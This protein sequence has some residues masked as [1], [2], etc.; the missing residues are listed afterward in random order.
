MD[1]TVFKVISQEIST[2]S[3]LSAD[4]PMVDYASHPAF[5]FNELTL[6]AS[7]KIKIIVDSIGKNL[8]RI[9]NYPVNKN[10]LSN[11]E[12]DNILNKNDLEIDQIIERVEE[13]RANQI[14]GEILSSLV[15]ALTLTKEKLRAEVIFK[16]GQLSQYKAD[17]DI[18]TSVEQL[19][20]YGFCTFSIKRDEIANINKVLGDDISKLKNAAIKNSKSRINI[21]YS[22]GKIYKKLKSIIKYSTPD[23]A[24]G[25]HYGCEMEVDAI[26]LEYSHSK[27]TWYKNCY[28]DKKIPTASTVYFH[29][30]REFDRHKMIINL[31]VVGKKNGPFSYIPASNKMPRNSFL[32]AFHKELDLVLDRYFQDNFII[33][34][35]GYYRKAFGDPYLRSELEKIPP[36]LLGHSHFGD[37]LLDGDQA[38]LLLQNEFFLT[39][40]IANVALF[41]GHNGIHRGGLVQEGERIALYIAWRV[42]KN[43]VTRLLSKLRILK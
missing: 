18:K 12:V 36:I 5:I 13:L 7:N 10:G 1:N 25:S 9:W 23:M 16:R 15:Q 27:S 2:E 8:N 4:Y 28:S 24:V 6:E 26:M 19:K 34:N 14:S 40:D 31:S 3:I 33:N 37:D 20:K 30:D 32:F 22:E 41:D 11:Q 17:A 35:S 38:K 21:C 42:K 39:S 29:A 43:I